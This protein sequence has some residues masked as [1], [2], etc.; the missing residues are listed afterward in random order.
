MSESLTD[1]ERIDRVASRMAAHY[2]LDFKELRDEPES[3]DY[4]DL[5]SKAF[6]RELAWEAT[7]EW[8]KTFE[9][10]GEPDDPREG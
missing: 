10:E 8:E 4:H 5:H 9:E 1:E 6:W 7:D 2:G 3:S